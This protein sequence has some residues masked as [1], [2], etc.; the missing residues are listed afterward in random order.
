MWRGARPKRPGAP[1]VLL[2][3]SAKAWTECRALT[4]SGSERKPM[5][6]ASPRGEAGSEIGGSRRRRCDRLER[7]AHR[8][9]S[10]AWYAARRRRGWSGRGG[11]A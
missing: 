11:N 2:R 5:A 7:V 4:L 9:G 6:T 10:L 1:F 3:R 8:S